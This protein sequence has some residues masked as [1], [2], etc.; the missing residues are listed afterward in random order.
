MNYNMDIVSNRNLFSR[1]RL[2]GKIAE[3]LNLD[4]DMLTEKL[5]EDAS[6]TPIGKLL[7]QIASMPEIRQEKVL[8]ARHHISQGRYNNLDDSLDIISDR[9]LEDMLV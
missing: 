3:H 8:K 2:G 7:K 9:L 1:K 5:I 4:N 6:R